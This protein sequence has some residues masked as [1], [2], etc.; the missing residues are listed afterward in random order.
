MLV[1][2][3]TKIVA[4]ISGTQQAGVDSWD[5]SGEPEELNPDRDVRAQ[6]CIFRQADDLPCEVELVFSKL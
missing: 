6:E 4:A 2:D 3:T 5:E 1:P